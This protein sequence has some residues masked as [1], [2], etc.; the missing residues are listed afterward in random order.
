MN[1]GITD[2]NMLPSVSTVTEDSVVTLLISQSVLCKCFLNKVGSFCL[3]F[4][5]KLY[6]SNNR[7]NNNKKKM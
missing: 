5:R 2:I 4:S 6:F 7:N 3:L 1:L